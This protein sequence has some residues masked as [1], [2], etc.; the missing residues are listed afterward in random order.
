[1]FIKINKKLFKV[2]KNNLFWEKFSK[3]KWEPLNFKIYKCLIKKITNY[4]DI[5]SW[6]GPT[7]LM[8][9]NFYPKEIY[10]FEPD[11]KAYEELKNNIFLNKKKLNKVKIELYN[12]AAY[13]SNGK[14]ILNIPDGNPGASTSSLI[15]NTNINY[16]SVTIKSLN[17]LNFMKKKRLKSEDFIKIDIEGGEYKLLPFIGPILRKRRPN[18]YLAPHPFLINGYFNKIFMTNKLLFSLRG[19][20]YMYQI[21]RNTL[22]SCRLINFLLKYRLPIIKKISRTLVFTNKKLLN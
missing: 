19:Y 3:N 21:K 1:M 2:K 14:I 13:L 8:A 5:G 6:I 12:K 9:A 20:K 15:K 7:V 10:A 4:Y 18:I 11:I 17:L 22:I 16:E